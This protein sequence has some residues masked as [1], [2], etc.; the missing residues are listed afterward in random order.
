MGNCEEQLPLTDNLPTSY[1][2]IT[3]NIIAKACRQVV[4]Q[5]TTDS[6]P[7]NGQQT[8]DR[9]TTNGR[10]SADRRPTKDQQSTDSR[11]AGAVLHNYR[12]MTRGLRV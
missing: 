10:L 7:T 6:R 1:R 2:H 11:L 9:R 5:Q 12:K 4:G 8:A 3:A